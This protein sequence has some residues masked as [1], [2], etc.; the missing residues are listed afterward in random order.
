INQKEAERVADYVFDHF[1]RYPK[2]SLG[3]VAFSQAQMNAIEDEI[4]RRR[5]AHP[6]LEQF[7]IADRLEGF[8]VKNLE[9]V[10]GDER[11]I[12]LFSIG[13]GYDQNR[14]MTMNFG[15]LN[16]SG[17]ERRLNVAVTRAREKVI[18]ISS[19]N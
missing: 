10:Q 7:F 11:D 1:A 5:L 12:I 9:N 18:V 3:V 16:K 4:E 8:F 17:G 14:R 2:K 15:P 19:I 6:E 13:Y